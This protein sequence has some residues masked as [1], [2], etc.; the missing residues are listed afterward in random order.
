MQ[1]SLIN[2]AFTG[3]RLKERLWR[4]R[5]WH[6]RDAE[7]TLSPIYTLRYL[8]KSTLSSIV[9]TRKLCCHQIS[10]IFNL[11]NLLWISRE[12]WIV[13]S[14]E[15]LDFISNLVKNCYLS[16]RLVGNS[17]LRKWAKEV[18]LM[19]KNKSTGLLIHGS[20]RRA[21][22]DLLYCVIIQHCFVEYK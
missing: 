3:P 22:I 20:C 16:F 17:W 15:I 8:I 18:N 12:N 19:E 5:A 1:E 13:K 14:Q 10:P 4:Y 7:K 11:E 2:V 21:P 6:Y 9:I